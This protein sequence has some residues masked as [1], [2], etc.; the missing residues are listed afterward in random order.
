MLQS[1]VTEPEVDVVDEPDYKRLSQ[2]ELPKCNNSQ[3]NCMLE[4]Y[5]EH[6]CTTSG[7]TDSVHHFILTVGNPVRVPL[8]HVPA[9]YRSE[10]NQQIQTMLEQGIFVRSRSP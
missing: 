9:H 8:R 1:L 6:F 5:K 3:L 4:G 2:F 7:M 10:V